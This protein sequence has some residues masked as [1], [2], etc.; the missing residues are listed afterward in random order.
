MKGVPDRTDAHYTRDDV[1]AAGAPEHAAE[2]HLPDHPDAEDAAQ[3]HHDSAPA[4]AL[5]LL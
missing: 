3:R 1:K 2:R 5:R 4:H